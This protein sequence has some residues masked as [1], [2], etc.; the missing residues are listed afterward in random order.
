MGS[1]DHQQRKGAIMPVPSTSDVQFVPAGGKFTVDQITDPGGAPSNVIDV[2]L[3]F[4]VSGTVSLPNWLNGKGQVCVY[5]DE[6]GGKIDKR[7]DPC[8]EFNITATPGE[9]KLKTYKWSIKFSGTVLPDPSPG[10]QLYRLA[11]VFL[12]GDQSTDIAAFNEMGLYL[13]N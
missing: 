6:L 2:D 5:A 13:I 12:F 7:L 4:E 3:G 10:S 9:P 11:A 1:A 8:Y